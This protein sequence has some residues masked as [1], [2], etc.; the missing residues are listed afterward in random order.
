MA[1]TGIWFEQVSKKFHR[2]ELHDS[3]RDLV[4]A[5]ARRLTGRKL[6]ADQL[7]EGDFWAVRDVTFQVLPGETLGIIGGNGAGKSTVLKMLTQILRPTLGWA[8]V[9]GRIGALIEI[10]A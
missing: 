7:R 6:P 10:S 2:G 5:L 3:L 8:K 4:P 1:T 9:E